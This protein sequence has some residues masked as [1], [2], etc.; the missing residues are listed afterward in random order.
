MNTPPTLPPR[1]KRQFQKKI[2]TEAKALPKS[3]GEVKD[4]VKSFGGEVE[5]QKPKTVDKMR[6][7][8][9]TNV[10]LQKFKME[11]CRVVKVCS[12]EPGTS[13]ANLFAKRISKMPKRYASIVAEVFTNGHEL[14]NNEPN[15]ERL[16]KRIAKTFSNAPDGQIDFLAKKYG[17]FDVAIPINLSNYNTYKFAM[18]ILITSGKFTH[19]TIGL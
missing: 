1:P 13:F 7:F 14:K 2:A 18:Y 15:A 16:G 9:M 11:E 8:P 4:I 17:P 5:K 12:N 3:T 19:K 10:S 6:T